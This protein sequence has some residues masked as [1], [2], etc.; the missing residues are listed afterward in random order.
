M[1]S[2]SAV[3]LGRGVA[4]ELL[5]QHPSAALLWLAYVPPLALLLGSVYA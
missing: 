3:P 2:A 5:L 1:L 4:A